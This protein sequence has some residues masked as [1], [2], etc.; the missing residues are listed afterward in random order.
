MQCPYNRKSARWVKQYK[1]N[2]ISEDTGIISS[3][4]EIL[5]EEYFLMDCPKEECGAWQN[6]RCNYNQGVNG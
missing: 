6:D 5:V 2:L 3:Q 4:E 1:N